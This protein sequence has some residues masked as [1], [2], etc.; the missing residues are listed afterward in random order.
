M[1]AQLVL[2]ARQA[3]VVFKVRQALKVRLG[4]VVY[5]AQQA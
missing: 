3:Q 1:S 5:K 2:L 4:Q